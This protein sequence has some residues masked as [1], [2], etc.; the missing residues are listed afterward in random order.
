MWKH[1]PAF[2]TQRYLFLLPLIKKERRLCFLFI[3]GLTTY[4]NFNQA[5]YITRAG[6]RE[7]FHEREIIMIYGELDFRLF[8]FVYFTQRGGSYYTRFC[9]NNFHMLKPSYR[10]TSFIPSENINLQRT[11]A[12]TH[13]SIADRHSAEKPICFRRILR[14]L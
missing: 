7:D 8:L 14:A 2:R 6:F 4:H 5:R 13:T 3:G 9:W 12:H 11:H 10:P 1:S